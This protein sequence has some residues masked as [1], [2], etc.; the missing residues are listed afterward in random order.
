M[1]LLNRHS[2]IRFLKFPIWHREIDS[3]KRTRA[4]CLRNR[5]S[6]RLSIYTYTHSREPRRPAY[7]TLLKTPTLTPQIVDSST[8]TLAL[9]RPRAPA[10]R[11]RVS[12]C[13]SPHELE[14]GLVSSLRI[15]SSIETWT[16]TKSAVARARRRADFQ[17]KRKLERPNAQSP[18]HSVAPNSNPPSCQ[19][20]DAFALASA[21]FVLSAKTERAQPLQCAC[22]CERT[23]EF[24]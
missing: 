19:R 16:R 18:N 22:S 17:S 3:F 11:R 15:A 7:E 5:L 4:R 20:S 13:F 21:A 14:R 8:L 23:C 24:R 6:R 1:R 9:S 2:G 10:V 12:I